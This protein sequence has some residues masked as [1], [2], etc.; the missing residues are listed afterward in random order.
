MR[1]SKIHAPGFNSLVNKEISVI[2]DFPNSINDVQSYK[3]R[4]S[5]VSQTSTGYKVISTT[6]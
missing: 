4:G 6:Y 5:F 1:I 2:F 3:H